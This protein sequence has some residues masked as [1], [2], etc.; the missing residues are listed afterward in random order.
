MS[1]HYILEGKNAVR[2]DLMTWAAW[3]E[4]G[5]RRVG[6]AEKDGVRVSTV[7]L[8]LDHSFGNEPGPVLYE[9]MIFGGPHD[10]YQERYRTWDEAEAGHKK[11]CELAYGENAAPSPQESK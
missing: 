5:E 4:K 7:F 3:L 11:A 8:G 1:D 10:Q 2:T 6:Q 9:T